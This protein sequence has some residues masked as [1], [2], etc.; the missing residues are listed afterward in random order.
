MMLHMDSY[1]T[2]QA[3]HYYV[4]GTLVNDPETPNLWF[5]T[6]G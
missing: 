2:Q 4:Y 1:I 3:A 5:R 6:R